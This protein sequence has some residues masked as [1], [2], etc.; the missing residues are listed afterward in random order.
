[1]QIAMIAMS[2][3]KVKKNLAR[4][5]WY[6]FKVIGEE[7]FRGASISINGGEFEQ[8]GAEIAAFRKCMITID[9]KLWP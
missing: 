8:L 1:M 3:E 4:T 6:H 9:H 7:I 5:E 2:P